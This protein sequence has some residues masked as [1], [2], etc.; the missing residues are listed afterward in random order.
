MDLLERV[1]RGFICLFDFCNGEFE[2][3]YLGSG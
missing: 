2:W 3:R 1:G